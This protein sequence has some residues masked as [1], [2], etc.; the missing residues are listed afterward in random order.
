MRQEEGLFSQVRVLVA[1]VAFV[2]AGANCDSRA[3]RGSGNHSALLP[4]VFTY[5]TLYISGREVS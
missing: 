2:T 3:N 4:G 5:P 1:S